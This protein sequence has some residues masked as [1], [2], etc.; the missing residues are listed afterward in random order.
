MILNQEIE[1][2]SQEILNEKT[3][4]PLSLLMDDNDKEDYKNDISKIQT[5]EAELQIVKTQI[6][7]T[8]I[9]KRFFF[10]SMILQKFRI[11]A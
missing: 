8:N 6:Q 9:N 10:M 1:R 5:I 3:N 7:K 11:E 2:F 4:N